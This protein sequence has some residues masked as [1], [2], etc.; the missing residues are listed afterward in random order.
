MKD[1]KPIMRPTGWLDQFIMV[2]RNTSKFM[3]L[4]GDIGGTG[5]PRDSRGRSFKGNQRKQRRL[6]RRRKMKPSAR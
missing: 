3:D 4:L 6:S 1:D 2:L 5:L